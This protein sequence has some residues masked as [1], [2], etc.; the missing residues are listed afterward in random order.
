M[1]DSY[2]LPHVDDILTDCA[3][4]EIWSKLDMTNSFFQIRVHPDD[5]PLTAVTTPFGFYEWNASGFKEW[6]A[7][8]QKVNEFGNA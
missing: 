1:L 2:P 5:I 6:P 4:G 3:K 8:S 7:D